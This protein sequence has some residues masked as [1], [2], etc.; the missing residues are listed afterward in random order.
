[1]KIEVKAEVDENGNV[2]I[3]C[4]YHRA[5]STLLLQTIAYM[6]D[7][8]YKGDVDVMKA[9]AEQIPDIVT[10]YCRLKDLQNE[11][12]I[13]EEDLQVAIEKLT[14]DSIKLFIQEELEKE[15]PD[16]EYIMRLSSE[17]MKRGIANDRSRDKTKSTDSI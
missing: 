12:E 3:Q 9:I 8:A 2:G 13:A 7:T 10:E 16:T 1:M 6:L 15:S 4:Q 17:L 14:V 11:V 5:S